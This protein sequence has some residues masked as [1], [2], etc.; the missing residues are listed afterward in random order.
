MNTTLTRAELDRQTFARDALTFEID[1]ELVT[2]VGDNGD[3]V[4]IDDEDEGG[5][6]R[7]ATWGPS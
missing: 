6:A 2:R 3:K 4:L 5:T 1:A 7:T